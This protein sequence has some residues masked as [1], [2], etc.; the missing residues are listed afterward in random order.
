MEEAPEP[1]W[2]LAFHWVEKAPAVGL[3]ACED[4]D[5]DVRIVVVV[6]NA[7]AVATAAAAVVAF[8]AGSTYYYE[9][10]Q[11]SKWDRRGTLD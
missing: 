7:V 4:F 11:E 1:S 9:D 3:P 8:S 5:D 2:L 10:A 6:D